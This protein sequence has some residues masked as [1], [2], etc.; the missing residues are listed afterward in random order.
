VL[1]KL[2][3]TGANVAQRAIALIDEMEEDA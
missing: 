2:G 1:E 3:F